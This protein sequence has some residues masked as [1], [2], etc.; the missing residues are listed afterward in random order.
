MIEDN[1]F[2]FNLENNSQDLSQILNHNKL[3]SESDDYLLGGIGR[4]KLI[5]GEGDDYLF[6]GGGNDT[7]LGGKGI[8]TAYFGIDDNFVD[9]SNQKRQ[10]TGEGRDILRGIENVKA[11]E[12]NDIIKGNKNNNFLYGESGDDTFYATLGN[13][14]YSFGDG[15]DVIDYTNFNESITLNS[16]GTVTKGINSQDKY[17]D[18]Y[19][20]IYATSSDSDWINGFSDENSKTTLDINLFSNNLRIDG[21]PNFGMI[22]LGIY[23]F[24]N[25][26]GTKNRDS[27]IGD[28]SNNQLIGND[29]D[30]FL[31]GLSGNDILNG[32]EG[33]D[34]F[35]VHQNYGNTTIQDFNLEEDSINLDF[36]S[37]DNF[38]FK[39]ANSNTLITKDGV[40]YATLININANDLIREGN[41]VVGKFDDYTGDINT[42]GILNVGESINAELENSGDRDWFLISLEE[43]KTYQFDIIGNSLPD[44]YLYLRNSKGDLLTS[45]DDDMFEI[46]SQIIFEANYTGNYFLDAGSYGDNLI[47]TYSLYAL[48]VTP[49][50]P[51]PAPQPIDPSLEPEDLFL[52]HPFEIPQPS[53][54][55]SIDGYG[56]A[57]AERAFEY[58]LDIDLPSASNLGGNLWGLDYIG[59]PVVWNGYKD[60]SGVTGDGVTI[61]VVDTGVDLDHPEFAGRIVPGYDFVDNDAIAEDGNG[62]GTHVAGTIAGAFDGNGITGVAYDANIMP[63]RVLDDDGSGYLSDITAGIRFAADNN[64]DVINLSLGGGGFNSSMYEAIQYASKSGSVVVMASGNEYANTPAYPAYYSIDY[65]IAVGAV[66]INYNVANFSNNAGDIVL[67]YVTAPG[68]DIYSSIIGGGYGIYSGTSMAAPHISGIAGLLRSYDNNLTSDEIESL[69]S[70][71]GENSVTFT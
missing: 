24:E 28:E 22:D 3:I 11:G 45:N 42:K 57:S 19:S 15:Y 9:L 18:F 61:A 40:N 20:A 34:T 23:N 10:D 59:A 5:G 12:G 48:D 62:H 64:A 33:Y 37:F 52:D 51:S 44:P 35:V 53:G 17:L 47:G 38:L 36:L 65:G 31:D 68:V 63:I 43:S 50:P 60:F 7:I 67:D 13:D 29:G 4:D 14:T 55:S 71:S 30:D 39:Q 54:F 25:V 16:G 66:D 69:I 56:F 41:R 58:I 21:I 6:G 1:L 26:K 8:D 46:D 2:F 49:L 70:S 27:I 32:G